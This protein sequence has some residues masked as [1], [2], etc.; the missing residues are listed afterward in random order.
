[1]H[2]IA[3]YVDRQQVPAP[4]LRQLHNRLANNFAFR[5]T[6]DIRRLHHHLARLLLAFGVRRDERHPNTL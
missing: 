2:V 4:V 1:M 3:L 6:H 5:R